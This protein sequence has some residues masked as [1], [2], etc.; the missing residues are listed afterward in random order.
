M[1]LDNRQVSVIGILRTSPRLPELRG[2][3]ISPV[4]D[5]G[6]LGYNGR[7]EALIRTQVGAAQLIARQAPWVI[8]PY[9]P[10][11]LGVKAPID[12]TTLRAQFET[13]V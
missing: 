6:T 4:D 10:K 8:N 5:A 12:P 13:Q 7:A 1:L 9:Q 3:V 2:A 11:S